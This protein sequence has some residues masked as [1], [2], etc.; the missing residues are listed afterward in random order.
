MGYSAKIRNVIPN[1]AMMNRRSVNVEQQGMHFLRC[2]DDGEEHR[3]VWLMS[4][5][6][7]EGVLVEVDDD[8]DDFVFML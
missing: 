6:L 5:L 4:S 7:E 8:D 1:N 2:D 3:E